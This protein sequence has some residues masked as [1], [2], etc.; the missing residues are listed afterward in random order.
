MLVESYYKLEDFESLAKM[1]ELM[2]E[3]SPLLNNIAEKL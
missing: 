1:I 2:P 3:G